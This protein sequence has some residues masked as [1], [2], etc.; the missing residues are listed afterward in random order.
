MMRQL[1]SNLDTVVVIL[2]DNVLF[3]ERAFAQ[4][5]THSPEKWRLDEK[6]DTRARQEILFLLATVSSRPVPIFL[7]RRPNFVFSVLDPFE[8]Y[9]IEKRERNGLQVVYGP[10]FSRLETLRDNAIFSR[11]NPAALMDVQPTP[12]LYPQLANLADWKRFTRDSGSTSFLVLF[13][14]F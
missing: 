4:L 14:P 10:R 2:S 9:L 6:L 12:Q 3:L 7:A 13:S 8:C 11:R 5:H 1:V